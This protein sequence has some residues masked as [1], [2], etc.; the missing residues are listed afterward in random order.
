MKLSFL[1]VFFFAII[2]LVAA[3]KDARP[4]KKDE[5]RPGNNDM[6][7]RPKPGKGPKPQKLKC[8]PVA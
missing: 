3:G 8:K 4:G 1:F 6:G 2:A 7:P 5:G